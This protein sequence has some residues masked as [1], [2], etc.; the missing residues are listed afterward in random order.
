[1]EDPVIIQMNIARY[2]ALL[3]LE[4]APEKRSRIEEMLVQ[5]ERTLKQAMAA[6]T[7]P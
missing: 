3:K 4:L 5:T 6:R 7:P 2:Q 1:M